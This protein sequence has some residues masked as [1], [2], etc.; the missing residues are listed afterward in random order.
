MY[1]N[2][3]RL[4]SAGWANVHTIHLPKQR[5]VTNEV[6]AAGNNL[7]EGMGLKGKLVKRCFTTHPALHGKNG[8]CFTYIELTFTLQA[9]VI[10]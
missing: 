1:T 8:P 4:T 9:L 2:A 7:L 3:T 5:V 6:G 10:S